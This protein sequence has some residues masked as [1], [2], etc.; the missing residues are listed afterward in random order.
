MEL[1][2]PK[3]IR[4]PVQV[5]RKKLEAK[6]NLSSTDQIRELWQES[7]KMASED[8]CVLVFMPLCNPSPWV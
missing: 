2:P 1:S 6:L 3:K 5:S 8:H 4:I 7:L